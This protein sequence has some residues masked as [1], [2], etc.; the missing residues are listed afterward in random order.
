MP[1]LKPFTYRARRG[2]ALASVLMFILVLSVLL[3][4]SASYTVSHQQRAYTDASYAA[5]MDTAEAGVNYE[6]RKITFDPTTADQYPGHTYNLA[7]GTATIY[8]TNR[9]GSTPWTPPGNLYVISTGTV[10]GVRRTVKAAV[11]GFPFT[12]RYAL[13]TMNGATQ[14]NGSSATFVGDVGTN[15]ALSFSAHPSITGSVYFGG[16]GAGWASGTSGSGY[17]VVTGP[18]PIQWPT[19]DQIALDRFPNSGATA[20]GGL[21]YL[22]NH[23]D[24]AKAQPAITSG[25]ITKSVTLVG[26]GNYYVTSINL[27]GNQVISIDNTNGPVNLWIGP[28]GG[29]GTC[30]FR[31]GTATV[32]ATV[33]PTR[34]NYIFVA[35]SSGINL[36][37]NETIDA[38]IVAY[39]KDASGNPYGTVLVSGNPIIHGQVLAN[40]ATIN[41][42]VTFNY[43]PGNLTPINFDYYGYDNSW[44]ELNP[45]D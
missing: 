43:E 10:N 15:G 20:P 36:A 38:T 12:G 9:D 2:A 7:G 5:S 37:G 6:F 13:Y 4:G 27:S 16:S 31:G 3:S 33:N 19:V 30:V 23:N 17:V 29:T 39:N 42:N 41:G 22:A 21:L 44:M 11:K 32:S 24:N 35:T 8:C 18:K 40:T 1:R 28:S 34:N 45:R 26:P 14:V 25:A